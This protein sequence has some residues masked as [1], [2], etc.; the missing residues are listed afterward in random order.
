MPGTPRYSRVLRVRAS[1]RPSV[2]GAHYST[3][4]LPSRVAGVIG[5]AV[6]AAPVRRP[7][8]VSAS[9]CACSR[10]K[11]FKLPQYAIIP[12]HHSAHLAQTRPAPRP[13]RTLYVSP[14]RCSGMAPKRWYGCNGNCGSRSYERGQAGFS[15]RKGR[16]GGPNRRKA[17]GGRCSLADRAA[18]RQRRR[19]KAQQCH[20]SETQHTTLKLQHGMRLADHCKRYGRDAL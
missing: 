20:H 18:T 8:T 2:Y 6:T 19:T 3:P 7:S 1:P 14:S 13:P 4:Y 10:R 12:P 11:V 17:E 9:S 15:R 5:T 16:Q